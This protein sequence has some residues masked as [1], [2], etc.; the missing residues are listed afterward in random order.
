MVQSQERLLSTKMQAPD[1]YINL[2]EAKLEEE[3]IAPNNNA[4]RFPQKCG[5]ILIGKFFS[6]NGY[7]PSISP[8][9]L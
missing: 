3:I 9:P 4:F 7:P 1:T 2:P 5:H 8:G 6:L